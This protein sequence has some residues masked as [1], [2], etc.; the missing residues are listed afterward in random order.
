LKLLRRTRLNIDDPTAVIYRKARLLTDGPGNGMMNCAGYIKQPLFRTSTVPF[1]KSTLVLVF[2]LLGLR[3]AAPEQRFFYVA[4]PLPVE[5]FAT[6]MYAIA[7]VETAGNVNAFNPFEQAAG[8]FQIRPVRV[9]DYN[10]RTG[11]SYELD[12]MF[13][14]TI[15]KEIF[16][17]YASRSGPYNFEQIAKNWNGSGPG[18]VI[19]WERVKSFL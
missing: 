10:L 4:E 19:Y 17:Y 1:K 16:L 3:L 5:P 6:L 8:I 13:D 18:T 11:S 15:S 9:M 2:L 7:M 14:Y 12:D